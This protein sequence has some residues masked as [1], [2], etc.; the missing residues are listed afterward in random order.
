MKIYRSIYLFFMVIATAQSQSLGPGG[1]GSVANN[2]SDYL[3][4]LRADKNVDISKPNSLG[5][6]WSDIS[7]KENIYIPHGPSKTPSLDYNKTNGM[8]AVVF[9]NKSE[10]LYSDPVKGQLSQ[11]SHTIVLVWKGNESNPAKG[12]RVFATNQG[13]E[14][15]VT[16]NKKNLQ[17]VFP[18][19]SP[20]AYA[21]GKVKDYLE[22]TITLISRT[23]DNK[24]KIYKNGV[25]QSSTN[26]SGLNDFKWSSNMSILFGDLNYYRTSNNKALKQNVYEVI[27][28]REDL[29]SEIVDKILIE[30]Y[31]SAKYN[32]PLQQNDV[33]KQDDKGYDYQV[34]GIGKDTNSNSNTSAKGTGII[35]VSN[36]SD[37][38]DDEYLIWGQN[39]IDNYS[40][41]NKSG[42]KR[43]NTIWGVSSRKSNGN[44]KVDVGTVTINIALAD[45]DFGTDEVTTN[46]NM[47]VSSDESFGN[48]DHSYTGEIN[49][50]IVTYKGVDLNDADYF[51]FKYVN[52]IDAYIYDRANGGWSPSVPTVLSGDSKVIIKNGGT[53]V[54]NDFNAKSLEVKEGTYLWLPYNNVT[55]KEEIITNDNSYLI[56]RTGSQL[57]QTHTGKNKNIGT[58]FYIG[59]TP[60]AKNK[61]SYSY[62]SSPVGVNKQ[63]Y[64][65]AKNFR[66]GRGNSVIGSNFTYDNKG[67]DG[68][69]E[70]GKTIMSTEWMLTYFN[71]GDW[72]VVRNTGEI[73]IGQG[74]T[75]KEPGTEA[76]TYI[77]KGIL[78]SGDY[79]FSLNKYTTSLLGN[80]YPSALDANKFL[81]DNR[82]VVDALYFY[83]DKSYSHYTVEYQA[84]YGVYTR[85][86]GGV[87]AS[88][89][90][91]GEKFE[92]KVPTRYIP[93]GQ[94][95][96]VSTPKSINGKVKFNNSQRVIQKL[97]S[98]SKFF[99]VAKPKTLKTKEY[100]N[101]IEEF[102]KE[103][104]SEPIAENTS[105]SDNQPIE[106]NE[107]TSLKLGFEFDIDATTKFH[108]QLGVN[109]KEG[110]RLDTPK[111]GYYAELYDEKST[112]LY[113]E[114]SGNKYVLASAGS[115]SEETEIP[116]N[117]VLDEE[118][119]V[120]FMIDKVNNINKEIFLKDNETGTN[121]SLKDNKIKKK[122]EA[123]IYN[124]RFSLT[125][126]ENKNL[127]TNR[128]D[129]DKVNVEIKGE[130]IKVTSDIY[131]IT[132][133]TIMDITGKIIKESTVNSID[134]SK[135]RSGIVVLKIET[136]QGVLVKKVG[137]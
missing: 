112:D 30:N 98:N 101:N 42:V 21:F 121:E 11:S 116:L 35:S 124:D 68:V 7:G 91:N 56:I 96:M 100:S 19:G 55:V 125:F 109:F 31:L 58:G 37:L 92:G 104:E 18:Q 130:L 14:L 97:G 135:I 129:V 44:N 88:V 29:E 74:M 13:Y 34:A 85:F 87:A 111:S 82:D 64:S 36:P 84:G 65:F 114:N 20:R 1:V 118:R 3:L 127:S 12:R 120:T 94:G 9:D 134:C 16:N 113:I 25:L 105:V 75:I 4:W 106:Q 136:K 63:S 8:P 119:E 78:N 66:D 27:H 28:S 89:T 61:Y 43:L 128:V 67:S 54:Y 26:V 38:N 48:I 79:E 108:R 132:S 45:L 49:D 115:L 81:D 70:N 39:T 102:L 99:K 110:N 22:P 50:G 86:G 76:Q 15:S 51:T 24:L 80:P 122:L 17:F 69:Q 83:E 33:Y 52:T 131:N 133:L 23:I 95:F 107:T 73:P 6:Q 123:G 77:A 57:L 60:P 2:G 103:L 126:K 32:I 72:N 53:I 10:K 47:I 41:V 93:V 40:F 71:N 137:I 46:L 117:V 5:L 90:V 62:I 59:F